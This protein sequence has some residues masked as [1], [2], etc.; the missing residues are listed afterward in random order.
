MVCAKIQ[1]LERLRGAD[2]GGT[3]F[4]KDLVAIKETLHGVRRFAP[5]SIRHRGHLAALRDELGRTSRGRR[6]IESAHRR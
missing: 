4:P 2:R 3:R 1:D 6:L 5:K